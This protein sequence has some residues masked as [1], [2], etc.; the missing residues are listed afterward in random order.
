MDAVR[1]LLDR[2]A[3]V[4]RAVQATG[5]TAL[6]FA[7]QHGC[8]DT[9]RL[10]VER[11]ADVNSA[12]EQGKT[13]H[14]L[15]SSYGHSTMAV[16]LERI[17]ERIRESRYKLVVLR[18]LAARGDAR[19]ERAFHGKELVLDFLFPGDGPP[20]QANKQTKRGRPR[21]PDELFSIIARYYC[22]GIVR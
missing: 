22:G 10:L 4:N 19:R 18:A 6:H 12:D 9:A 13:P 16:W 14:D 21:L 5:M 11:G 2:G 3:S 15:A 20:P 8:V 1:L 7:S 17:R